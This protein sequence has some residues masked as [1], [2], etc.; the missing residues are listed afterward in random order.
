MYS[1]VSEKGISNEE[2]VSTVALQYLISTYLE[3]MFRYQND[4]FEGGI[5][6]ERKVWHV[7]LLV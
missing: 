2:L 5:A 6:F 7:P 4:H 3:T 1:A